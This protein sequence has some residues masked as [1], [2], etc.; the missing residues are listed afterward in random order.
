ME[1]MW[2]LNSGFSRHMTG[3]ISLLIDFKPNKKGFVTYGDNNKGEI[4][5]KGSV[6]M[7]GKIFIF[8]MQVYQKTCS[9]TSKKELIILKR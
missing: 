1:R 7:L 2:F 4:L 9:K 8:M 3:D 6:E 5:G